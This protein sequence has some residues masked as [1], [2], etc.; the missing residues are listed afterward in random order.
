MT[1]LAIYDPRLL[2]PEQRTAQWFDPAGLRDEI[3]NAVQSTPLD[4]VVQ[5]R[6]ITG[7]AGCGKSMLLASLADAL[8]A[9]FCSL[10][11]G[12]TD[13]AGVWNAALRASGGGD[14]T[15]GNTDA[16][17]E[18][19]LAHARD[20][21]GRLVLLIDGFDRV[22]ASLGDRQEWSLR[23]AMSQHPELAVV[24]ATRTLPESS[25]SYEGAFFDFFA[26]SNL[27]PFSNE[28]AVEFLEHLARVIDV[29]VPEDA[30]WA[31]AIATLTGGN[32]RALALV[33]E[34]LIVEGP[35]A[36]PLE[37]IDHVCDRM[38]PAFDGVLA[39]ISAQAR[40]VLT[41][42]GRHWHPAHAKT[43][44]G[45]LGMPTN[46]VST[47]LDRLSRDGIVDKVALPPKKTTGFQIR[48]RLLQLWFLLRGGDRDR[49]RVAGLARVAAGEGMEGFEGLREGVEAGAS[50][51]WLAVE[52]REFV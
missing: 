13:L 50:A 6:L 3:V 20:R 51:E 47:Y 46:K 8:P 26:L 15:T 16:A 33:T 29:H 39:G 37:C 34:A 4:Q 44:A 48:D 45:R 31:T 17:L 11:A 18:A 36:S 7:P 19:L 35:T 28:R 38:S 42:L 5:H 41:E 21:G 2:T 32:P 40:L 14:A 12:T 27:A 30:S 43:I 52:L 22:L 25:Y 49:E 9:A 24:A 10:H 23:D 1:R